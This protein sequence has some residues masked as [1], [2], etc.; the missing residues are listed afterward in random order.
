MKVKDTE[1]FRERTPS[2]AFVNSQA[3]LFIYKKNQQDTFKSTLT[4]NLLETFMFFITVIIHYKQWMHCKV[5]VS[6]EIKFPVVK[7]KNVCYRIYN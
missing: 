2:K 3:L 4:L 1:F 7:A 5:S 6:Q